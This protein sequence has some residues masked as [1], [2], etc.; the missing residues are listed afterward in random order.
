MN[1]I[2]QIAPQFA[3]TGALGPE[4][5]L[6]AA[7]AGFRSVISN[8]PDGELPA[9]PGSAAAAELARRA[10][11]QF[12][13]LPVRKGEI[14]WAALGRGMRQALADLPPPILAHCASGQRSALAWAAAAAGYHP[15]E[16]VLATLAGRGFRLQP[17]RAELEA[18]QGEGHG[19]IPAAL[20]LPG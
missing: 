2:V 11:L 17:L 10:G 1:R 20:E 5:L 14:D 12:R 13:H 18:L 3:V 6:A 8:L 16:A 15:A 19:P 4:D 7:G 9:F